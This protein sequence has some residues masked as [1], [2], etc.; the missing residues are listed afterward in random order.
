MTNQSVPEEAVERATRE[1]WDA[2]INGT[3]HVV[4]WNGLEPDLQARECR[5][6]ALLIESALDLDGSRTGEDAVTRMAKADYY[7]DHD[8]QPAYQWEIAS[9]ATREW[10]AERAQIALDALLGRNQ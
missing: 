10:Y 3:R 2:S 1:V 7:S 6:T 8:G 9:N 5:R 4:S